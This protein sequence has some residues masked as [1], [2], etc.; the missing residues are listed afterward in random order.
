VS[1]LH[2]LD[3]FGLAAKALYILAAAVFLVFVADARCWRR[4]RDHYWP[5]VVV[6]FF[7]GQ[8]AAIVAL[9]AHIPRRVLRLGCAER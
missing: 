9:R 2:T 8:V 4:P 7:F 3:L 5:H 1:A 6:G